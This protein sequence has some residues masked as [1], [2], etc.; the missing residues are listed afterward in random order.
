MCL[1]FVVNKQFV[2]NNNKCGSVTV[3]TRSTSLVLTIDAPPGLR[4]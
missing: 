1:S 2:Y 4:G 3:K